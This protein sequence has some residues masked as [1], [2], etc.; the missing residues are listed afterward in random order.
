[1]NS[2]VTSESVGGKVDVWSDE[3]TGTEIKVTF[4]AQKP[5][6]DGGSSPI[7]QPLKTCP[8]VPERVTIS[9]VGFD[10]AHGGVQLLRRVVETYLAWWGFNILA[11][12]GWGHIV[13]VNDDPSVIDETTQRNGTCTPFILLSAARGNPRVMSIASDHERIG[14]FCRILFKPGG[15]SRL[16]AILKLALHTLQVQTISSRSQVPSLNG[17]RPIDP[18]E[19][20]SYNDEQEARVDESSILRRKSENN[21]RRYSRHPPRPSMALR[22][23]TTRPVVNGNEPFMKNTSERSKSLESDPI[24]PTVSVGSGGSLLKKSAIGAL[25]RSERRFRV[26]VIEDNAILRSLL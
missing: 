2:I 6:E 8:D 12:P 11:G 4:F 3:G 17:N 1:M 23:S 25:G 14:G 5:D 9:L 26:L 18:S 24:E 21:H 13:I 22:A 7:M 16:R 10:E 20:L 19:D 15:P